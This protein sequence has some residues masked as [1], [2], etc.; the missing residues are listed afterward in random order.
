MNTTDALPRQHFPAADINRR[1]SARRLTP[2][3]LFSPSFFQFVSDAAAIIVSYGVFN[4]VRYVAGAYEVPF[5]ADVWHVVVIPAV[6]MLYW[7][8][9]FWMSGLYRD[10]FVRSPFDEFYAVA[11]ATFWGCFALFLL[12]VID[13]E[14]FDRYRI[15]IAAFWVILL[16]TV[17]ALRLTSRIIQ[18]GL[19]RRGIILLPTVVI[20]T[21]QRVQS[22]FEWIRGNPSWGYHVR[23]VA[24]ESGTL[25]AELTQGMSVCNIGQ[26]ESMIAE[27]HPQV[28][29]ISL[30]TVNHTQLLTLTSK[31][32]GRGIRV[33]I[34]PDLYEVFTGLARTL[35]MYGAPL[36]EITTQI[37]RPWQ[38]TAKRIFDIIFS[39]AVLMLGM[40]LWVLIGIA[41]RMESRGA[42]LF[43]QM[44]IGKNGKPFLMHKYRSMVRDSEK[45]GQQW[46]AINDPRV[47]K[48][49]R[50][51]R[52][53]HLDEIPQFWNVLKGEMSIV[54]PRP[55]QP[56]FVEK[57][58]AI[59][60][61]Y[62]RRLIVRP[63]ITGWWQVKYKAHTESVEEIE[64]RL[65]DDFYYIE[66]LSL[67]LD[68]EIL[69]RT[70]YCVVTGHGQT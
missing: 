69:I 43:N 64:G 58:E 1:E 56:K 35:P 9:L 60:P 62:T 51:L 41:I 2:T 32:A 16:T 22:L 12:I 52:K 31:C 68:F 21:A 17:F 26:T 27:L 53:T 65:R 49:G 57:Y 11:K 23:G 29:L 15:K 50:F 54:G 55:E 70:V 34:V 46:T 4:V 14:N 7:Q 39:A 13:S 24:V 33:K 20:G 37:L 3:G 61:Y 5:V 59:L 6:M 28:V 19:R 66:N 8:L 67:K 63:G 25:P 36:I 42:V 10:W 45:Q 48:F 18:R 30:D 44:R 40:P 47:T 38:E